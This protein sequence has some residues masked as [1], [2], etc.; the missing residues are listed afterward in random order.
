MDKNLVLAMLLSAA[1]VTAGAIF[2]TILLPPQKPFN[3][4]QME[5]EA[6]RAPATKPAYTMP[7]A[8]VGDERSGPESFVREIRSRDLLG[9]AEHFVHLSATPYEPPLAKQIAHERK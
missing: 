8:V 9:D 4:T 6:E 7:T 3:E 2:Q 1:I 5:P